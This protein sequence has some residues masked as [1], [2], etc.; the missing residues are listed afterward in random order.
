MFVIP[1]HREGLPVSLMEAIECSVPC[2]ASR[3]RGIVDL[4]PKSC[5]LFSPDDADEL[6]KAISNLKNEELLRKETLTNLKNIKD[7]EI[8]NV[9]KELEDV[10]NSASANIRC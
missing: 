3:I 5:L 10:Y 1:S 2:S 6:A 9:I 7:Y 4:L 8:E